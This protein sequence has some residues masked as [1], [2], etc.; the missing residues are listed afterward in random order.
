MG[1]LEGLKMFYKLK[2][3][4]EMCYVIDILINRNIPYKYVEELFKSKN[5]DYIINNLEY[6]IDD[7]NIKDKMEFAY[8][9]KMF[10]HGYGYIIIS[11]AYNHFKDLSMNKIYKI[12]ELSLESKISFPIIYL[13]ASRFEN[14]KLEIITYI[15]KNNFNNNRIKKIIK[16]IRNFNGENLELIFEEIK[17]GQL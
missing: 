17:N 16:I 15:I 1:N 7:L 2:N 11:C 14:L 4:K 5:N 8:K 3:N 9:N 10:S 13:N 12:I 6:F